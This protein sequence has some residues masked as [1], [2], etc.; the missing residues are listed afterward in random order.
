MAAASVAAAAWDRGR[1]RLALPV[2]GPWTDTMAL[3]RLARARG[4][5]DGGHRG[6]PGLVASVTGARV[7]SDPASSR[8]WTVRVESSP[9][10]DEGRVRGGGYLVSGPRRGKWV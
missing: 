6:V 5:T 3:A 7:A 1:E 8:F 10:H 2:F 9:A 4:K